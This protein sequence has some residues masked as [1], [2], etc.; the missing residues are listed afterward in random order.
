MGYLIEVRLLHCLIAVIAIAGP[1]A[2][3]DTLMTLGAGGLV[4]VQSTQIAMEREDLQISVHQI[5]V[6]YIFRNKSDKDVDATVAF[7]LPDLVGSDFTMVPMELP[8]KA[9]ANFVNFEVLVAGKPVKPQMEIRAFDFHDV[10]ITDRLRAVGLPVLVNDP[11]LNAKAHRVPPKLL[12]PF[13]KADLVLSDNGGHDYWP[14]WTTRV[15]FYWTQHFPA[16]A[17]VEVLHKY[18]PVVGGAYIYAT[19][20]GESRVE[21]YCGGPVALAEIERV[22]KKYPVRKEGQPSLFERRIKYILTTANNWSGPIGDF[23]LTVMADGPDDLVLTCT[24]GLKKQTGTR[25]EL[26]AKN[27]KPEQDLDVLILQPGR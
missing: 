13:E 25:Y 4:P 1:A 8:S 16:N 11:Q 17:T 18:R 12:A 10:D 2:A 7:P 21:P 26:E 22:K 14:G 27:F 15:K 9:S 19:D 6:H 20:T 3:N 24:K 23:R 5:T